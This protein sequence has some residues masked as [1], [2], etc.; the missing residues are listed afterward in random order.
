MRFYL[1][2]VS[3]PQLQG[4][5]P[6]TYSYDGN[7]I[8]GMV[9][10]VPFRNKEVIGLIDTETQKPDFQTKDI[11]CLVVDTLLPESTF[12]L[13][14]WI[15]NYY[16]ASNATHLKLFLP[17]NLLG[18]KST[19]NKS[20][21]NGNLKKLSL[22]KLTNEQLKVIN[23]INSSSDR[24]VMLHGET[25]SG[26][27]R[28]Y[29]ELIFETLKNNKS[30][31]VLTP[32]I[33]LTPQLVKVLEE[34]FP[35]RII[36]M[37]SSL[38]DKVRRE[39]WLRILN[40]DKPLIVVGPRSALFSPLKN[41]GLVIMDEAHEASYK[42][43]QAPYYQSSRVAAK[44]CEINDAKLIFGTATP[45]IS[46]YFI[47]KEKNLLT[48]RM[49]KSAV[50][51]QGLEKTTIEV[52]K[53]TDRDNFKKTTWLS[54]QLIK[55]ISI[56]LNSKEQSIV[57]LNRRGTAQV[58]LCQKCGWQALCPNCDTTLTYHGDDHKM[59]CHTCNFNKTVPS[60][61][62][63]CKSADIIFK[64]AG[65]KAIVEELKKIFPTAKISR[66]D[67][68]NKKLDSLEQNY[69]HLLSG[70]VDIIV[71]TQIITKGLDLPLL[72][73]V[74]VVMADSS[75]YF[76][77]Y[78]A[79]ERTFQNLMQVI[80]RVGRGHLRGNVIVQTYHPES[81]AIKSGVDKNYLEFYNQQLVERK[82][83]GYPPF[84]YLLKI[85]CKRASPISSQNSL[86]KLK[87]A[88]GELNLPVTING[89]APSFHEK[90]NGK[91]IW[92]LVV[93]SKNRSHL[94][95]IINELPANFFYDI[96]PSSLL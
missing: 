54:D 87:N 52:V 12:K 22:P 5:K 71:G 50:T 61:C 51:N 28:V 84:V 93:K 13:F 25:S 64:G 79:E 90:Q 39:N 34:S 91:Y 70:K 66:F 45:L 30:A 96:D 86:I 2:W 8:S 80:G 20:L 74:G 3:T 10:K 92:Q 1:V 42:Q 21:N 89:P 69:D 65:T 4:S 48:S 44:L 43:E 11:D 94:L 32:E 38:T 53:I 83:F 40:S 18:L 29:V 9:V 26:K 82:K 88:L 95:K 62:P 85:T 49:T 75:L 72:T 56:S 57:F 67:K 15:A 55:S 33:G 59:L 47:V 68:D 14:K 24:T 58:I 73:T 31:I 19:E 76:P 7:L 41:L 77:D 17:T 23:E 6:L 36:L 37:H 60:F 16:P 46:D 81:I 63:V 35:D 78:M 27:T